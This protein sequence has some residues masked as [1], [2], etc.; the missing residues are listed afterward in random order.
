LKRRQVIIGVAVV[1]ALLVTLGVAWAVTRGPDETQSA[2]NGDPDPG[3]R[4]G[5]TQTIGDTGGVVKNAHVTV[6]VEPGTVPVGQTLTVS[7]GDPL[8]KVTGPYVEE[9]WGAPVRIDHPEALAKPVTLAWNVEGLTADQRAAIALVRWD[10]Q[11]AAWAPTSEPVAVDDRTLTAQ[12]TR[13]SII[14]FVSNVAANIGQTTGEWLGKRAEAPRCSGDKLPD[15]V[16]S[17]VRPDETL[18]A[19]A[20]RTCVEPD[21]KPGVVT[22]RIA[23]N[24]SFAQNLTVT[25]AEWAWVWPGDGDFSPAGIAWSKAHDVLG[26]KTRAVMPPTR[27]MAFGLARPTTSGT[28]QV[29]MTAQATTLTIFL[30]LVAMAVDTLAGKAMES[31]VVPAFLE[32][33]YGCGGEKLLET[34]PSGVKEVAQAAIYTARDCVSALI[35]KGNAGNAVVGAYE[36]VL[37]REIA[38]GGKAAERA[39][40]AG[41]V[42]HQ[43]ASRLWYLKLFEVTDYVSNQLADALVGPTSVT[44]YVTGTP[45]ALGAWTATCT[46]AVK[47]SNQ[48]YRNLALQDRY[49]GKSELSQVSTWAADSVTAVKPLA[50]CGTAHREAVAKQVESWGDRTAGA[51]VA[52][53][54]RDLAA[55]G[56]TAFQPYVGT[57]Q[58]SSYKLTIKPDLTGD[59]VQYSLNPCTD[60][61]ERGCT[62]RSR[63]QFTVNRDGTVRGRYTDVRY[64]NKAGKEFSPFDTGIA[65]YEGLTFSLKPAG[66]NRL[67]LKIDDADDPIGFGYYCGPNANAAE[68]ESCGIFG[69]KLYS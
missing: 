24:R 3:S 47:D 41:R 18:S 42:T 53:A 25:G 45:S 55:D 48:L 7:L 68:K 15:W 9:S 30:D 11:L 13:F 58:V 66:P 50:R 29:T 39:A 51:V 20:L 56:T 19:V 46:D 31:P 17:V 2:G 27:T 34:R 35:G 28:V 26:T 6:T 12:V 14:D 23:N 32:A 62:V 54:I 65:I 43:I 61:P 33:L 1:V 40:Q 59:Q 10:P 38:K 52:K 37:R 21:A 8:G 44:L 49:A 57:W 60:D 4:F 22:I 67:Q 36:N 69:S 64:L 16:E 63:I 5:T